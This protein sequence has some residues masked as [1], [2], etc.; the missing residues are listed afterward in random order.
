M[1]AHTHGLHDMCGV[2]PRGVM[3]PFPSSALAQGCSTL[4]TEVDQRA[5]GAMPWHVI[6][7]KEGPG[8]GMVLLQQRGCFK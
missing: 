3:Y 1:L 8:H 7:T 6:A 4:Y 5:M 2:Q